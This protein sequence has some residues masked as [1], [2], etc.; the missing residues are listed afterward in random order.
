MPARDLVAEL[1]APVPAALLLV[2]DIS[3][4]GEIVGAALQADGT[5]ELLLWQIAHPGSGPRQ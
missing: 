3:N 4:R 5:S 2:Y 1:Q